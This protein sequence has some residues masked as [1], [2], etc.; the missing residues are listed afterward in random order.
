MTAT[1]ERRQRRIKRRQVRAPG[2]WRRKVVREASAPRREAVQH[3]PLWRGATRSR[4]Q[5][6][7]SRRRNR[8][9]ATTMSTGSR[10]TRECPR[11]CQ[12]ARGKGR[13]VR[14]RTRR[15]AQPTCPRRC[16]SKRWERAGHTSVAR[17]IVRRAHS[18]RCAHDCR[19]WRLCAT[20]PCSP[21]L[22]SQT[23]H[24]RTAPSAHAFL[25]TR[26]PLPPL[27]FVLPQ[28]WRPGG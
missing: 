3:S 12:R 14:S 7:S 16:C 9:R 4:N 5:P 26:P 6:P 25:P 27:P 21:I 11:E 8:T 10:C 19:W 22:W 17:A 2:S 24:A 13:G 1:Q 15:K 28:W 20:H 18:R 23:T